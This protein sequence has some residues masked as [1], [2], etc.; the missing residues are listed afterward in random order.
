MSSRNV[1]LA[2]I[3]ASLGRTPSS[4]IA[5]RPPI[6]PPRVAGMLDAEIDKLVREV[7]ALNGDARRLAQSN[8][9][10]A[11]QNLVES[12]SI[13]KAVLWNTDR[14]NQLGVAEI[15]RACGVEII[16]HDA[17]KQ[18]LARADLGITEADFLLPETG[19]VG[20]FSSPDKPRS[21]SLLPRVHLVL[22]HRNALR[23][24]LHHVFAQ[25][26]SENYLVF[27][28]GPSRTADIEMVLTLGVH[29]PKSYCLWIID[30]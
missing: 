6:A 23:A 12:E 3:R 13:R 18:S 4:P 27:V 16:P 22:A 26:Q 15:L 19:T 7:T 20:L 25:A 1:I 28:T 24:D 2:D 21:V 29:G 17:D 5:R 14:L 30:D 8:V 10:S 11:L 9:K